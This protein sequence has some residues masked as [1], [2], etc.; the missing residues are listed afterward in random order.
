MS[1][2]NQPATERTAFDL[3]PTRYVLGFLFRDNR[4]SVVLIRKDKP[5]W[6]AGLLNGVGGK[7]EPGETELQAMIR[8]FQEETGV[9]TTGSGWRQFCE[10]SGDCFVVYCF[11]ALDSDAWEK[12]HTC[13]RETVEKYHPD[14][15]NQQDCVSN[16]LWLVE[17]AI[18]D[19]YGREFYGTIRYSAPFTLSTSYAKGRR[20]GMEEAWKVAE[21]EQKKQLARLIQPHGA[22]YQ[23]GRYFGIVTAREAI[24]A[25]IDKDKL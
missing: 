7:I 12:V 9:N 16:L 4:T 8:E 2:S 22:T 15:L 18:D 17:M 23:A 13:E 14:T 11:K 3:Q 19:N 5:K 10:M 1:N 20:D 6:Q 21:Q 25:A 24:R